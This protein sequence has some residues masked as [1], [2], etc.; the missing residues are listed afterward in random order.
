MEKY[1]PLAGIVFQTVVFLLGGYA[2]VLRTNSATIT[3]KEEIHEMNTELAELKKV[4]VV[5]AVQTT[6]IDN[7]R[8][9]L[10]M[11]Q[12]NVE[13]LRRGDG[14]VQSRRSGVDGEY[15]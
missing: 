1:I 14:F 10:T 3:L 8:D 4:V 13:D 12:R 9:Q 5:Q 15:P 2:M 11:L 7:I 6:R